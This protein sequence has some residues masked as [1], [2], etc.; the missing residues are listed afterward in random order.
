MRALLLLIAAALA[1]IVIVALGHVSIL[2]AFGIL[3][4]SDF[5]QAALRAFIGDVIGVAVFTPFLL[6]YF[7]RRR[8]PT[9]SWE[10]LL[11]LLVI[12]AAL[13]V[14]FGVVGSYRLQ[15]FYVLFIPIIWSAVRFGLEGV[16]AAL[17]VTQIGLIGAIQ[18][19]G[20]NAIDVTAYQALMV[21]LAFT[22][23]ALGVLVNAQQRA[24]H[25]L[26]LQQEALNRA[27]RLGT[28]GEFAAAVA[29]EINQP[30]TAIANYAR[31]AK[32]AAEKQPPDAN[33]AIEAAGSAIEQVDRAAEVVRRLRDFIRQGRSEV[34]TI[35]V[36]QLV[37]EAHSFCRPELERHEIDLDT[38]FARDLPLV[39]ADALQIQQVIVNLVHNSIEALS[40]AG[41]LDGRVTIE[42]KR[43]ESGRV[44]VRVRDNGPGF[45]LDLAENAAAPFAT[46]K[47]EGLG[48]GL[49]LARSIVEA[50][51][52]KLRIENSPRGAS[53][54]FTL[55]SATSDGEAA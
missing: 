8:F 22:G 37:R 28:M 7:T 15:L 33:A 5:A 53:V 32:R 17:V 52:V 51:G 35:S 40:E 20:Q 2:V 36:D 34:G 43:D 27:S 19:S 18:V 48:L 46:T 38:Q 26:R 4:A 47:P 42:C 12:V 50:H 13:L 1:S 10:A 29:H 14:V 24:R 3:N 55:R 23:L 9:A 31:L 41:R 21:V 6:I 49:S 16:T 25:Q 45:D 11:I 54:Y 44:E 39:A 30:L